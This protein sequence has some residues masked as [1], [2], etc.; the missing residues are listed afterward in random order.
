MLSSH[1]GGQWQSLSLTPGR[2]FIK[3]WLGLEWQVSPAAASSPEPHR[4]VH[5]LSEQGCRGQKEVMAVLCPRASWSLADHHLPGSKD[6]ALPNT[7]GVLLLLDSYQEDCS[8]P[9][10]LPTGPAGVGFT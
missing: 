10:A 9:K 7:T 2:G 8:F 4:M 6:L 5:G 3:G 1:R